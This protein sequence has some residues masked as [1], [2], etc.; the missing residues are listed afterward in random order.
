VYLTGVYVMGMHFIGMH[1]IGVYIMGVHHRME[2]F[3]L[4]RTYIFAAFGSPGLMPSFL[5]PALGG[6]LALGSLLRAVDHQGTPENH[7]TGSSHPESC[8]SVT[9]P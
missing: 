3:L 6:N 9:V 5:I 1:L 8:S 7:S 2:P 4:S